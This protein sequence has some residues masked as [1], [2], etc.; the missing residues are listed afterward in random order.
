[1]IFT[2][3]RLFSNEKMIILNKNMILWPKNIIWAKSFFLT[4]KMIF[5]TSSFSS[6]LI[7][8]VEGDRDLSA[9]GFEY[10]AL[11]EFINHELFA[12]STTPPTQLSVMCQLVMRHWGH[13]LRFQPAFLFGFA[14]IAFVQPRTDYKAAVFYFWSCLS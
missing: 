8:S 9:S 6:F 3:Q 10:E 5:R 4:K 13:W 2:T 14:S 7:I 11:F 1:M 12:D